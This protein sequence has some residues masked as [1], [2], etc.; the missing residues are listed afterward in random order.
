MKRVILALL[1]SLSFSAY[2]YDLTAELNKGHASEEQL[3]IG[4]RFNLSEHWSL[5]TGVSLVTFHNLG[6]TVGAVDGVVTHRTTWGN[7]YLDV[8]TGL[9]MWSQKDWDI[10]KSGTQWTFSNRI[11]V[12]MKLNKNSE[13]G[14][15]WR[16]YSNLCYHPNTS[17]DFVGAH[18]A[19]HF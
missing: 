2:G 3:R 8:G 5:D 18:Y 13:V 4:P 12:G 14:V 15:G 7:K 10:Q 1:A 9:A 6:G 16:H 19:F 11:G 17:K